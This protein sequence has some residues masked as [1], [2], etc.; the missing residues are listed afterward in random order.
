MAEQAEIQLEASEDMADIKEKV[1]RIQSSRKDKESPRGP[2]NTEGDT[3]DT[4]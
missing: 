2:R 3:G 1:A 4:K